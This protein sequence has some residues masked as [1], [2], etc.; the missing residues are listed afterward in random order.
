[1]MAII[2]VVITTLLYL[3]I[4]YCVNDAVSRF[5]LYSYVAYWCISLF[6][7]CFQP[8]GMSENLPFTYLLLL[9]GMMSFYGGFCTC[10]RFRLKQITFSKERLYSQITKVLANKFINIIYVFCTIFSLSY[11]KNALIA[12]ALEEGAIMSVDRMEL[13]FE[14]SAISFLIYN[15]IIIPVFYLTLTF[16]SVVI[17]KPNKRYTLFYIC[18]S[19]F[20]ISYVILAGG[21][22]VFVII[23]MYLFLTYIL[24]NIRKNKIIVS[25]KFL[26]NGAILTLAAFIGMAF[27][28]G[29]RQT[30]SYALSGDDA[31]ESIS[32]MGESFLIYSV[33]P[34]RLFDVAIRNDVPD[35]LGCPHFGR[36]TVAGTDEIACGI[37]RRITGDRPKSTIDIVHY[38][39]DTWISLI[40]NRNPFNYCY[41]ALF[42]NYLDYGLFG[43]ILLPFLFG[44]LLRISIIVFLRYCTIPAFAIVSFGYFMMLHSLFT[45]YFIKNW[46]IMYC[47]VLIIWQYLATRVRFKIGL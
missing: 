13:I 31:I 27:Q 40:P 24:L 21:R 46:V 16:L 33:I 35:R 4:K 42:Y 37:V 11:A 30:G 28:T 18:A 47:V 36:A 44:W 29:Y 43:I 15:Y 22:S 19:L 26:R 39:Q 12:A 1:M 10:G 17:V 38:T 8:Y 2:I 34:I 20:L 5:F 3:H 45:C 25:Y 23:L 9:L 7:S 41:T 6:V 32:H 14:G